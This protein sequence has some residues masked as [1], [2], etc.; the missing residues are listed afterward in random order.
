MHT[1]T[2]TSP[3]E[4]DLTWAASDVANF[5]VLAV[6]DQIYSDDV[7]F[8]LTSSNPFPVPE[9]TTSFY[10]NTYDNQKWN[11]AV[12][13]KPLGYPQSFSSGA[14]DNDYIVEFYG[15][16]Y[17]ADRKLNEFTVTGSI[18]KATAESL[19]TSPKRLFV[20]SHKTNFTGS[21]L[22]YTDAKVTSCR[23]WFDYLDDSAI[24]N[25][26][27]DPGNFGHPRPNRDTY[28]LE[29]DLPSVQVPEIESLALYWD[30]ETVTGSDNGSGV[31]ST[32]DGKFTVQDVTSGSVALTSRYNWLG[33]ILKYQHTGRGDAFPINSTGSVETQYL[34]A[35]RQQ[36]P[37]IVFG[38]DNIR[39][40]NQEETEVF[41]K[42]T[43][44]TKTYYA[45]E[46]S[47]YQVIS[48]EIINYFGSIADFNNLIGD[49]VNRYR[50]EYK[51]LNYL[52]QF[53][54]ERVTNTPDLDK[55][56]SYY[57]WI[58][59][60]LE[61]MLMQLVPASAQ[62]SD[63]IDNV[64]ESHVL[65]RNKYWSKF[66]TLEFNTPDPEGG[67]VSINKH[68]YNW[69]QGHRPIPAEEDD[70]CLYWKER[71]ERDDAPISSGDAAVD[72]NRS[73]ILDASLQVLNRRFTTPYRYTLD[74]TPA[75]HGGINYSENKKTNFYRG[76]NF[77][78]GPVTSIG[79]PENV[80]NA[81]NVDVEPLKDCDDV[82]VP[83]EKK[84]YSFGTRDGRSFDSGSFDGI[85]GEIAMPFNILS[86]SQGLG[87]YNLLKHY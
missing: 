5:Q 20:G 74:K 61:A 35:G 48:D 13:I 27:I 87:G 75:I 78:H 2:A 79:L 57:K 55:F 86:A 53:F 28:L 6:R 64:V 36:L 80:L 18:A 76:V 24:Q 70:N 26:A 31:P 68:L 77:P 59:S 45:F 81:W 37:E 72:S 63:G 30:F 73:S 60:T 1:P 85:K 11:F 3:T 71:A 46:K 82:T 51:D 67:A 65:E 50:Q 66:P 33:P 52:R 7:K 58:D 83:N 23:Y 17:V 39:V 32:Y 12:R 8:V 19:L 38:D 21:T 42:E 14:L 29:S 69:K 54:F 15:V 16:N 43:R 47:M 22:Q 49:P 9:L 34:Y 41:T 4:T 84:K 25:H 10:Q 44:P 62:F 40:L 56:I